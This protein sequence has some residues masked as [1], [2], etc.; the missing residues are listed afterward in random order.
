MGLADA[1]EFEDWDTV[2]PDY[3]PYTPPLDI[4]EE[5]EKKH[6]HIFWKVSSGH[7]QNLLDDALEKIHQLKHQ[8]EQLK[9]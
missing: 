9:E 3:W 5:L 8:L 6:P 1:A 4:W 7:H 2:D